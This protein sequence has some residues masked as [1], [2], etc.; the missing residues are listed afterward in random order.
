MLDFKNLPDD[1]KAILY[2]NFLK[3]KEELERLILDYR[4]NGGTKKVQ[5]SKTSLDLYAIFNTIC[6][7]IADIRD[8]IFDMAFA[9][10]NGNKYRPSCGGSHVDYAIDMYE[11]VT[12]AID[13]GILT[14]DDLYDIISKESSNK[15]AVLFTEFSEHQYNPRKGVDEDYINKL[16]EQFNVSPDEIKNT[17]FVLAC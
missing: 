11:R 5:K 13:K 17:L 2:A 10:V 12:D 15:K 3:P 14:K 8:E 9:L 7:N 16:A 1:E 6:V 4:K